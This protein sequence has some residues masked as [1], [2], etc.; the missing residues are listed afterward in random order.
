MKKNNALALAAFGDYGVIEMSHRETSIVSGG[1]KCRVIGWS[2]EG[3]LIYYD[4]GFFDANG[5]LVT[6]QCHVLAPGQM[7]SG[8][9]IFAAK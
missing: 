4:Y 7:I 6:T 2:N 9:S 5:Y 3:G 8:Q 1:L